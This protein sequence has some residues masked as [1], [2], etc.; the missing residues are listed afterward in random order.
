VFSEPRVAERVASIAGS[1]LELEPARRAGLLDRDLVD[2][3]I[4]SLS[5]FWIRDEIAGQLGIELD[6]E[7]L[8]DA[9][10]LRDVVDAVVVAG[11]TA[12]FPG[13]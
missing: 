13:R 10:T 12:P 7:T 9:T 4:N 3:G 2:A 8:F 5:L 1:L 6:V 11:R